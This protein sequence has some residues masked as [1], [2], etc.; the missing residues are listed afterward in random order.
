MS[1][2]REKNTKVPDNIFKRFRAYLK[3]FKL[4]FMLAV[5]GMVGY[6]A[7][8]VAVVAQLKPIVDDSLGKGDYEYL[9]MASYFIVPI[10]ILRGI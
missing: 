3:D 1:T 5:I 7:I 2:K 8:D 9:R 6:S 4:A 10:F